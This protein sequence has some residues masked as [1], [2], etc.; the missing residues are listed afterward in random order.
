MFKLFKN[1]RLF[2]IY[3]LAQNLLY[4]GC[5]I[6]QNELNSESISIQI[7]KLKKFGGK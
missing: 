3:S 1:N 2:D 7:Q 6:I 4:M 5:L